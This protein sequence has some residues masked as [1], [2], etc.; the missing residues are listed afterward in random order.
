VILWWSIPEISRF[1]GCIDWIDLDFVERQR[2]PE[3]A[4]RL[5]IQPQLAGLSF[6]NTVL[7]LEE[8]GVER[9]PKAIHN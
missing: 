9:S 3:R 6:R 1:S 4:M 5:G 2:T 8:W 7:I